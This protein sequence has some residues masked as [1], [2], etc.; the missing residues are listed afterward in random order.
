LGN[1]DASY[2]A[3]LGRMFEQALDVVNALPG[4]QREAMLVRLDDVRGVGQ[5]YG[6]GVGAEM[7]FLLTRHTEGRG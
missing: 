6:Y 3:A 4:E 1:D 2:F 7:D 5:D